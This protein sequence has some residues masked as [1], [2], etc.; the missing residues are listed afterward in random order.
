M[1]QSLHKSGQFG[2]RQHTTNNVQGERQSQSLHKSGQFGHAIQYPKIELPVESQSLHKSGQ[3]GQYD[4]ISVKRCAICRNPF[5]NQVNS[6]LQVFEIAMKES[7][8]SQSLHKSG[9]FGQN[10]LESKKWKLNQCRNPFINQ[11]NSDINILGK[12]G[13]NIASR[14]PFINQV[15]S[16]TLTAATQWQRTSKSRNP[17]INQVNSDRKT[18]TDFRLLAASQSLH[19]SGQFGPKRR[20]AGVRRSP[21]R[22]NPFINQVNSD[23]KLSPV[24]K[25]HPIVAI[26]S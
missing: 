8:E 23:K 13:E 10:Q 25:K 18:L 1:S 20:H 17:F 14:N 15:N 6:D 7:N 9:Q 19:K 16:D 2:L 5:I 26:P 21:S 12:N 24:M 4:Y 22:R 11:V 3:F